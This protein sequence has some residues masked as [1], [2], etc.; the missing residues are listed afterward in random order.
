MNKFPNP[1]YMK[2]TKEDAQKLL[3]LF[4]ES[5]KHIFYVMEFLQQFHKVTGW[6]PVGKDG[7]I[8]IV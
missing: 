2:S 8:E 3:N 5:H 4:F 7:K 1:E 6:Q